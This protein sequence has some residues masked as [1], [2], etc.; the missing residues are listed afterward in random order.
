[1]DR[2]LGGPLCDPLQMV[3]DQLIIK[4]PLIPLLEPRY[5]FASPELCLPQKMPLNLV[6]ISWV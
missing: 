2:N 3:A 6:N 4:T 5:S 1:M